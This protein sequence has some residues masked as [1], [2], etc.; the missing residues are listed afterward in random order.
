VVLIDDIYIKEPTYND[1]YVKYSIILGGGVVI[2]DLN[3]HELNMD[4]YNLSTGIRLNDGAD[5]TV[6]DTK[7]GGKIVSTADYMIYIEESSLTVNG[8]ALETSG[9]HA[10]YAFYGVL[11]DIRGGSFKA[12]LS[13]LVP[14][15]CQTI[16]I[17]GGEFLAKIELRS[18][19]PAL[20]TG[21]VINVSGD[22]FNVVPDGLLG[23]NSETGEGAYFPDGI[24]IRYGSLSAALADGA[25][26][27][28]AS[29]N[30]ITEG[31]DGGVISGGVY[32]K[33]S[34]N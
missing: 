9:M 28:D 13:S 19:T 27:F 18:D 34:T 4:S 3:G 8:G 32:V 23:F 1:G 15:N 33:R 2:L 11:L 22:D 30:Q 21:G 17:S 25:A 12:D 7:G 5:L 14:Q 16:N 31:L 29:G 24:N 26:Y 10:I 6:N 20:I